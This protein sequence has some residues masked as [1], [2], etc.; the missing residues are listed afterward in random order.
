MP[1]SATRPI[2]E[3]TPETRLCSLPENNAIQ[4]YQAQSQKCAWEHSSAVCWG[5]TQCSGTMSVEMTYLRTQLCGLPLLLH[6]GQQ[7]L[8]GLCQPAP[9]AVTAP[10]SGAASQCA[11]DPP[12]DLMHVIAPTPPGSSQARPCAG[13]SL[14]PRLC[15]DEQS[16]SPI[17]GSTCLH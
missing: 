12:R 11:C 7:V 16:H 9:T 1:G 17:A 13:M 4:C 2:H 5:V 6:L 10:G 15:H 14:K 8:A 3:D